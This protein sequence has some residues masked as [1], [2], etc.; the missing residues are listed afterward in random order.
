MK[1]REHRLLILLELIV[2]QFTCVV[3]IAGPCGQQPLRLTASS[4][5]I[6]SPGYDQGSYQNN[7]NCK[8]IIEAPA[9]K[10]KDTRMLYHI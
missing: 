10:V 6:K 7:A 9:G 4:G 5:T 1:D 3:V 8:W 2:A